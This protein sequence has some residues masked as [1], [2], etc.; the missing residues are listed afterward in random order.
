MSSRNG[1]CVVSGIAKGASIVTAPDMRPGAFR[2]DDQRGA[3]F[4]E[5]HPMHPAE[6]RPPSGCSF[7]RSVDRLG[8][9]HCRCRVQCQR[10]RSP[11][12]G[13][14]TPCA[15]GSGRSCAAARRERPASWKHRPTAAT[16]EGADLSPWSMFRPQSMSKG[17]ARAGCGSPRRSISPRNEGVLARTYLQFL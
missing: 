5:S 1:A 12:R 8:S 10:A 3:C 2:G 14:T 17:G 7:R 16:W 6:Q 15:R 4:R 9:G 11:D 13:A